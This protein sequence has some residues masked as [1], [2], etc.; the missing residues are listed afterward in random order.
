MKKPRNRFVYLILGVFIGFLIAWSL[1]WWQGN[2]SS[3]DLGIFKKIKSLISGYSGKHNE[4]NTSIINENISKQAKQNIKHYKS[5]SKYK[6]DSAFYDTTNID[7]YDPNALDEFLAKYNGHLPDSLVIDSILKNQNNVDINTYS[8]ANNIKIKKDKLIYAKFYTVPGVE[9]YL[10]ESLDKSDTS[11]INKED[12]KSKTKN[13]LQVEFWKS[14][15]NYKGY[16]TGKNKLVLFGIDQYDIVSFK[17]LNNT[18]YMKY[19]SDFYEIDKTTEFK[20]IIP[21]NNPQL[22]SQLNND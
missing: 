18:L 9:K 20:S 19:I 1:L 15:I 13:L 10:S 12:L 7:L 21:I 17:I 16:K 22:L 8:T 11:A 2:R 6:N 5:N 14:P 4:N 3:G